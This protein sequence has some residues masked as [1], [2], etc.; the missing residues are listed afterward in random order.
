MNEPTTTTRNVE[1]HR[2]HTEITGDMSSVDIMKVSGL[3]FI[4]QQTPIMTTNGLDINTHKALFRSDNQAIL[5]VVGK[6]YEPIQNHELFAFTD[7][8]AKE[9]DAKYAHAYALN[10]GRRVAIQLEI[11]GGMEIKNDDRVMKY[12]T[13]TGSHDGSGSV[14]AY[15][16]AYRLWCS[17]QLNIGYRNRHREY[18]I[19]LRHTTNVRE[20]FKEAQAIFNLSIDAFSQFEVQAKQLAEKV[21]D[22]NMVDKFLTE[23]LGEPIKADGASSVRIQNK[24]DEVTHLFQHGKGND[25]KTAWDLLNGLTEFIDH[26]TNTNN[27]N[28]QYNSAM[29]GHGQDI[30]AKAFETAL[31]L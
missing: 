30:K 7:I 23:I 10:D 9:Y 2:V 19:S 20:R 11:N 4:A 28:K 6:N 31:A 12:I 27:E 15:A 17:N 14:R 21:V 1:E 24:R 3:D 18:T 25:G 16:T 5:G 8:L 13:V 26:G 22:G 29:F